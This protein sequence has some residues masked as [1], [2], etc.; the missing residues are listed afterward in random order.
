MGDY[1]V[2]NVPRVRPMTKWGLWSFMGITQKTW[3]KYRD[4]DGDHEEYIEM[5]DVARHVENIMMEQKVACAATDQM[6]PS[7][8]AKEIGLA[9]KQEVKNIQVVTDSGDNEW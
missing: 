6:N 8:I 2:S 1:I 5:A 4:Y 9:E 3:E 7:F